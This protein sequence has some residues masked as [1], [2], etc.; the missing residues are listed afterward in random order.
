MDDPWKTHVDALGGFIRAQRHLAN[1]SLRELA[2]V[3]NVSS[4]YLSQLERGMHAPSVKVLRSI[5]HGLEIS[6]ETLLTQAGLFE[7]DAG[8]Q[9]EDPQTG[10]TERAIR[11]DSRL[12]ESQKETLLAVYRSYVQAEP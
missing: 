6:A 4:A 2:S 9:A 12:T 3:A 8:D 1:L 10:F 11:L 7:D 5:A